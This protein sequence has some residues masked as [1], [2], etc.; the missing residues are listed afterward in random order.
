MLYVISWYG[1]L[2]L[3]KRKVHVDQKKEQCPICERS[4]FAKY[5]KRHI[6]DTHDKKYVR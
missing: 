1:M 3:H 2:Q 6:A 5:L 4:Y